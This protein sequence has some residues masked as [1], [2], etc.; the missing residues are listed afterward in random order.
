MGRPVGDTLVDLRPIGIYTIPKISYVGRT[1]DR[2]TTKKVPFG[3]GIARY[4]ELARGA[5]F[6]DSSG[7]LKI[8][9]HAESRKLLGVHVS[10]PTPPTSCTSGC[11]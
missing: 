2:L 1:E 3:L 4:R 11:P 8:R 5:I 10:A 6:G 9:V 7:V